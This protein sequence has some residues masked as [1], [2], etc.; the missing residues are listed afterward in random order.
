MRKDTQ[1]TPPPRPWEPPKPKLDGT[2]PVGIGPNGPLSKADQAALPGWGTAPA[3]CL[4]AP[5]MGENIG[6]AARA[7]A[8]FG[9]SELILVKPRDVWPNPKAWVMASGAE[10]PLESAQVVE[11]AS[12][13]IAEKTFVI[14]TTGTPRQVDKPLIGPRQAV[15]RI[16][17][18]M[19]SGEKPV[20]LFG[21]E[22]SGLDNDL[23]IGADILVTFPVDGRFPSLNLAQSVAC[24][25]Y[26]WASLS[27]ADG[28]P[29]GWSIEQKPTAPR[30]AFESFFEHWVEELDT[31]RFFWP[32]DR[33]G[34]MIET[35]R[36]AFVRAR[37]TMG[38]VS[39][40]RGAL[41]S[42]AGGARRRALETDA[43]THRATMTAW[44]NARSSGDTATLA[45]LQIPNASISEGPRNVILIECVFD[46]R[47]GIV[48]T[49]NA[50][51]KMGAWIIQLQNGLI[52]DARY[53]GT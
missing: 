30:A 19:Q 45:S 22:R 11:T 44:L 25:C 34:T 7:M 27:E 16:R 39:L 17:E 52:E 3:I 40:M 31:T 26:E 49:Q 41:R 20:I 10:W 51:G 2:R 35:M 43:E 15:A 18:A 37:L 5:Q 23:I 33:K 28:P 48:L 9:F 6:A 8:N 4:V 24:L 1:I 14:A 53:F 32:N 42:L 12:E 38:E 21:S 36:N 13:A 47:Q 46:F 50:E 29:P